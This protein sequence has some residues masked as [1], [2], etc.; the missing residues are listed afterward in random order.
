MAKDKIYGAII[1]VVAALVLVWYTLF[2]VVYGGFAKGSIATMVSW[3][4]PEVLVR[5]ITFNGI[6]W[7]WAVIGPI[8]IAAVLVLGIMIWIGFTMLTTPPPVPL[9]ELEELGLEDEE[10]KKE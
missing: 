3:G 5:V 9:E 2:A 10:E 4:W 6:S 1:L 7:V 8:Y